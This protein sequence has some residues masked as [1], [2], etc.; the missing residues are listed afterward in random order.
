MPPQHQA[1]SLL[2]S[3]HSSVSSQRYFLLFSP[4]TRTTYQAFS[5][6]SQLESLTPSLFPCVFSHLLHPYSPLPFS[7]S[8]RL[9]TCHVP[10]VRRKLRSVWVC[11]TLWYFGLTTSCLLSQ[12]MLPFMGVVDGSTTSPF[13]INLISPWGQDEAYHFSKEKFGSFDIMNP[14][15]N[16]PISFL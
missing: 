3:S 13:L 15:H 1:H 4:V 6:S 14:L 12:T 16:F 2:L 10:S 7:S 11:R 5:S 9:W 8:G